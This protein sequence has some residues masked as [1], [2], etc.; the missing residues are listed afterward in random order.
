M[1]KQI[2]ENTRGVKMN[3]SIY[4]ISDKT[5]LI[6]FGKNQHYEYKAKANLFNIVFYWIL[7]KVKLFLKK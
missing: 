7:T 2:S 6:F 3:I 5:Y 4:E 1:T